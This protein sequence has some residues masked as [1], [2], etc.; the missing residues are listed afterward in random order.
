M[1]LNVDGLGSVS[2]P[3]QAAST[4][5]TLVVDPAVAGNYPFELS[6][7]ENDI[8]PETLTANFSGAVPDAAT[9]MGLL[10]MSLCALGALGRRFKK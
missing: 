9:T 3:G 7:G 2:V 6:Y 5:T 1:S 4:T 10:G 8:P